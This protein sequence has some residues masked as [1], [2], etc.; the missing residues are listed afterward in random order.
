[1]RIISSFLKNPQSA[2]KAPDARQRSADHCTSV[3]AEDS[4]VFSRR[5]PMARRGVAVATS[6]EESRRATTQMG[7]FQQT[8]N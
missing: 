5:E 1:M 6:Q 4:P 2:Q 7:L 3:G 8:A